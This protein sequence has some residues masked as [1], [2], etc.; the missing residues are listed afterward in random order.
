[1]D[2]DSVIDIGVGSLND[3]DG[4]VDVG[5]VWIL[6]MNTN[7]TV[8]S[9]QKIS[10]TEGNFNGFVNDTREFYVVGSIG[11]LDNDSI[12]DIAVGGTGDDDGG[13]DRG[14]VW[15]LF[16]N[17][18]GTVKSEQKISATEGNFSG[19]LDDEDL[20]GYVE[21]I[22]DFDGD[23]ISD[24]AVGATQDDDGGTNAGA[25]WILFL[26]TDGTVKSHTKF[27]GGFPGG[28]GTLADPYIINSVY[29]GDCDRLISDINA[30]CGANITMTANVD[31]SGTGVIG[32]GACLSGYSGTFDGANF[33]I[34]D[35]NIS[36][37]NSYQAFIRNQSGGT[38]KNVGLENVSVRGD[39]FVAGL[40]GKSYGA[41]TNAHSTGSV[42][43]SNGGL[44]G[45]V[46]FNYGTISFSHSS[47]N[48]YGNESVLGSSGVGGLVGHNRPG[49]TIAKSYAEGNSFGWR[50]VGGLV[51]YNSI[52]SIITNTYAK[53]N[54]FASDIRSGGLVGRHGG[55]ISNSYT[56]GNVSSDALQ[57]GGYVGGV[58]GQQTV[59][60]IT[61]NS[62]AM[63]NVSTLGN[64][65]GG[66]IGLKSDGD[67]INSYWNNHTGNPSTCFANTTGNF[68]TG[69]VAIQ[70][71]EAYFK[72]SVSASAPMSSW[73][74]TDIWEEVTSPSDD[75]P[76]L[77]GFQDVAP[78]GASVNTVVGTAE[79][80]T[81][82]ANFGEINVTINDSFDFDPLSVA[83][84]QN[85]S[86]FD[87][88]EMVVEFDHDFDEASLDLTA[89][90]FS[91]NLED[92]LGFLQVKG[93]NLTE[94]MTKT[95][96]VDKGNGFGNRV[97]IFDFADSVVIDQ[98][99][100]F[101]PADC[102]GGSGVL[103]TFA[104]KGPLILPVPNEV[105]T[106]CSGSEDPLCHNVSVQKVGSR[107]TAKFKVT[108]LLHT[109]VVQLGDVNL[110][111]FDDSD[112]GVVLELVPITFFC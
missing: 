39:F 53:G 78:G 35:L 94:G 54:V 64:Y 34:S 9:E 51:G 15:I 3:D 48:V 19:V 107:A 1:L 50:S 52:G 2:N 92:G 24:L 58:V 95:L 20:F 110:T 82:D 25:V 40:V 17:A 33:T 32:A 89:L 102:S 18:N 14:A 101:D 42:N 4:G 57:I 106:V 43:G 84:V 16:M 6:F 104:G 59:G 105:G 65:V 22:G 103:F 111:I 10:A 96:F 109:S 85:V 49:G 8:K 62:F 45:L 77:Q 23:G 73:D 46:G 68:T 60:S 11:D 71:N 90:N 87:D 67:I 93:I 72:G 63:G 97:C 99:T 66:I 30:S 80:I 112:F 12:T 76:I 81:V 37:S 41:I 74:F 13:L 38:I 70:D 27:G 91:K 69:C 21:R 79:N 98:T 86:I 29:D 108:G 88:L 75:F 44:G 26:N 83:G 7:G 47:V 100:I 55:A 31:C 5:A 28:S 56:T 36:S 61:N